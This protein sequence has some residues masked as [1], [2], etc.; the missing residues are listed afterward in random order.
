MF[1]FFFFY[2]NKELTSRYLRQVSKNL[3]TTLLLILAVSRHSILTH[4]VYWSLPFSRG[5]FSTVSG[6]L[7]CSRSARKPDLSVT[8]KIIVFSYVNVKLFNQL[9]WTLQCC[10]F[11]YP[12]Y[13]FF[14][15]LHL[16]QICFILI[17][18]ENEDKLITNKCV[19]IL[20]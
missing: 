15:G 6:F 7:T 9:C 3:T 10:F 20:C 18:F 11:Y 1:S 12:G 8:S 19:N 13:Q 16:L 2:K 14:L 4:C 17:T 5:G